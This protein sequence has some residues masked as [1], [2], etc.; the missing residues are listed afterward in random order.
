[1]TITNIVQNKRFKNYYDIY[2]N[3]EYMFFVT[4]KE[5][6]YLKFKINDDISEEFLQKIYREYI[7]SRAKNRALRLLTRKDMTRKEII[8]KLK[9]TG[10]NDYITNN[11]IV[12]LEE[13]NFINDKEYV[14]KYINY[15]KERKSIKQ[16]SVE[17]VKKGI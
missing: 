17:L 16:I 9:Q 13:Y 14:E 1:M 11:I 12:F 15:N 6:K 8:K 10:Y 3:E 4:Y 7:I 2:I 5:L